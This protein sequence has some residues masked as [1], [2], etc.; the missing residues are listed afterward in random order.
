MSLEDALEHYRRYFNG[1]IEEHGAV[2][3]G[4]DYNGPDAQSIRFQQ[5]V[6]VIDPGQR[7]EVIDFGCGYGGL[8][9]FLQATSWDFRYHGYDMLEKM[10]VAAREAHG[11]AE[12]ADFTASEAALQN[13]DYVIAGA[14][15]NNKFEA[16]V[17]AWR[18]HTLRVLDKLNGLGKRGLAFNMLS[19]YSDADR[20][21][22]RPDL[23]FA[24][25]LLYFDYCKRNFSRDVALLHDYG[26]YDFTIIVR[27]EP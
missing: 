3:Q 25:P 16:P 5:L 10:I 11:Q 12:N 15:F 6:K 4:V 14:I 22:Q 24:D 13:S 26:L 1:K 2:P 17:D 27:K 21:A 8:L 7:F 19:A 23:Y 20:M 9:T 18:E